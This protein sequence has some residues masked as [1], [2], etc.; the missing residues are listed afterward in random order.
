MS[1]VTVCCLL[2]VV[3]LAAA[4][5]YSSGTY[6]LESTVIWIGYTV[7]CVGLLIASICNDIANARAADHH[8]PEMDA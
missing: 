2:L 5:G 6:I 3:A 8:L 4:T 1:L 7:V